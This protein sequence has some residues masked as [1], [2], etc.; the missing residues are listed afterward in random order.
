[1]PVAPANPGSALS[2]LPAISAISKDAS[3]DNG[4]RNNHPIVTSLIVA[5]PPG[6]YAW[7]SHS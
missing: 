2:A 3:P 5:G 7:R 1:M 6:Q 4:K